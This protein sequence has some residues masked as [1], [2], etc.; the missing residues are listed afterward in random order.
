M[1]YDNKVR[2][3]I[4]LNLA[5][6]QNFP[7][8][9]FDHA[10][11]KPGTLHKYTDAKLLTLDN[12]ESWIEGSKHIYQGLLR[13]YLWRSLDIVFAHLTGNVGLSS[14]FKL[15]EYMANRW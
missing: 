12:L 8:G 3:S 14:A 2:I 6:T 11:G 13:R 9:A 1:S 10:R 7:K 15:L 4:G 5:K